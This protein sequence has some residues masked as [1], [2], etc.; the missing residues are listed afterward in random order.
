MNPPAVLL[1]DLDQSNS[2]ME[3]QTIDGLKMGVNCQ[4]NDRIGASTNFQYGNGMP[5]F[6][7]PGLKF[8]VLETNQF[9][10]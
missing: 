5:M 10:F 2:M 3:P 8:E 7:V 9:P 1:K 4:L 6:G